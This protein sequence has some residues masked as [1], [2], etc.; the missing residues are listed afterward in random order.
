MSINAG[1]WTAEV[2]LQQL[3]HWCIVRQS[4][5]LAYTQASKL[6]PDFECGQPRL[7]NRRGGKGRPFR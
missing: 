3:P 4:N 1:E 5:S 6:E 2:A 7:Y